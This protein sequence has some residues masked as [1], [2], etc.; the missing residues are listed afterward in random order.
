MD[1]R[2][3]IIII[4]PDQMRADSLHHLGNEA[5]YT[6]NMDKIT[7]DGVSF[8]QAFCQNP[9]CTPSRCSF[10][11]G[12]YPHVNGHRTMSNLLKQY[13]VWYFGKQRGHF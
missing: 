4:N 8:S 11:T 3:N 2:P 9:V 10:L 1:P 7:Q 6:P 12:L 5:A 13:F